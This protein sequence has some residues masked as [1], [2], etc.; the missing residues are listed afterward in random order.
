MN[1]PEFVNIPPDG[2]L[3]IDAPATEFYR[4]FNVAAEATKKGQLHGGHPGWSRPSRCNPERR[5]VH[6]SLGSA[7]ACDGPAG[8]GGPALREGRPSQPRLRRGR[9]AARP[10]RSWPPAG[11]TRRIPRYDRALAIN[12]ENPEAR[13]NLGVALAQSDLDEAIPRLERAVA[14]DPEY[15][16]ARANLGMVLVQ[17]G[18]RPGQR[19]PREGC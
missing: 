6:N 3:K 12:P 13:G 10:P 4:L 2:L 7:L 16:G 5:R 18:R 17:K 11:W 8:R 19:P 9:T 14:M 15:L 1:I